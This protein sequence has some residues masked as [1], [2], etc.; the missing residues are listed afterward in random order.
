MGA[1]SIRP[2]GYASRGRSKIDT[3]PNAGRV[4]ENTDL[5]V[6]SVLVIGKGLT[7]TSATFRD[8]RVLG[9]NEL[10]S[11]DDVDVV[12]VAYADGSMRQITGIDD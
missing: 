10:R 4:A 8:Q 7:P 2:D 11:R 5:S 9:V 3:E 1:A 12:I 6:Q